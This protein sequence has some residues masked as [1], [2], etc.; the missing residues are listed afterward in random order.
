MA[1]QSAAAATVAGPCATQNRMATTRSIV[2]GLIVE[3]V[4]LNAL[5]PDQIAIAL[6]RWDMEEE[7]R[8]LERQIGKTLP[9]PGQAVGKHDAGDFLDAL[10]QV[11]QGRAVV[12]GPRL[13]W[14]PLCLLSRARRVRR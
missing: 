9:F 12:R 13:H 5:A 2:A 4:L 8:R 3:R 7:G 10:Q 6:R 14:T 1:S 11:H